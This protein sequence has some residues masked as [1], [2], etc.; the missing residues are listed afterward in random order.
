MLKPK[1]DS[2]IFMDFAHLEKLVI[3]ISLAHPQ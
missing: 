2:G 1:K 3:P